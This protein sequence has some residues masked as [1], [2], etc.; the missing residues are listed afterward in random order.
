MALEPLYTISSALRIL[1]YIINIFVLKW[2]K[3]VFC[4]MQDGRNLK[5][6]NN[7]YCHDTTLIAIEQ[8][9]LHK[10]LLIFRWTIPLSEH[11][12]VHLGISGTLPGH[13]PSSS[14][15]L[16]VMIKIE[17]QHLKFICDSSSTSSLFNNTAIIAET[18]AHSTI[19]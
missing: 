2:Q 15:F 17:D 8:H 12:L 1:S 4:K 6:K 5:L 16:F 11:F 19:P 13:F 14:M 18:H 7:V 10:T 3:I 9:H